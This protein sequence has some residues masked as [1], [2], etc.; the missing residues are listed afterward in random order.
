MNEEYQNRPKRISPLFPVQ[1][2]T[3]TENIN[4]DIYLY[5]IAYKI[6]CFIFY[7]TVIRWATQS[8]YVKGVILKRFG[9]IFENVIFGNFWE[10]SYFWR[11]LR[12]PP[13]VPH[14]LPGNFGNFRFFLF[15]AFWLSSSIIIIH[16]HHPSSSI[17][18]NKND[19]FK[20]RSESLQN[21]PN[22]VFRAVENRDIEKHKN[23]SK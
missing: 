6:L 4:I 11:A 13:V 10:L 1:A 23:R 5:I 16:H 2:V 19:N 12:C 7:I 9:T 21:H 22:N 3:S 14:R 15:S 8:N 20:N 17:N 18:N